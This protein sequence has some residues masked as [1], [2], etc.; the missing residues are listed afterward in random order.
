MLWTRVF[1]GVQALTLA[2]FV[3]LRRQTGDDGT[4][5]A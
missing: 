3:A 5:L 1:L 4:P 2:G